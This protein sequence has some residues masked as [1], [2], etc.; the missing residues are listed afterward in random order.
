LESP[1]GFIPNRPSNANPLTIILA[2]IGCLGCSLFLARYE[3]WIERAAGLAILMGLGWEV[4]IHL[5]AIRK[6]LKGAR[7]SL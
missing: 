3:V 6:A 7:K 2:S 4:L 1:C 5:P